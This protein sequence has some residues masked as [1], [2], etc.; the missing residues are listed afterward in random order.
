MLQF[1]KCKMQKKNE[2]KN[3]INYAEYITF[4]SMV[5]QT[6]TFDHNLF[7]PFYFFIGKYVSNEKDVKENSLLLRL[8]NY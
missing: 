8:L 2:E 4:R 7:S 1:E 3:L 6:V 5:L